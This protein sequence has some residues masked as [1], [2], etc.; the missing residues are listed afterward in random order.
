MKR[1]TCFL[2]IALRKIVFVLLVTHS[3]YALASFNYDGIKYENTSDSTVTVVYDYNR[4]TTVTIPAIVT[5]GEKSYAVTSID[6]GAFSSCSTLESITIPSSVRLIGSEAFAYCRNLKKVVNNA[7]I[8]TIDNRLFFNCGSLDSVIIPQT[9]TSIGW[10][11]FYGCTN[12]KQIEI[13]STV[14]SIGAYAFSNCRGIV[15]NRTSII[16]YFNFLGGF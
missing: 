1:L 3:V 11:A 14:T 2:G 4:P 16:N 9:V 12:L 6:E 10:D 8:T 7:S 15:A 5:N 13:P